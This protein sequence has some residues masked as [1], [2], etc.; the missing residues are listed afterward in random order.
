MAG[1]LGKNKDR[2]GYIT[3]F[4]RP[5]TRINSSLRAIMVISLTY[6]L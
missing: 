1:K 2:Y 5:A 4:K 6:I 3:L